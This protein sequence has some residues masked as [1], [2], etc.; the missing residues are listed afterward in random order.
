MMDDPD[1]VLSMNDSTLSFESSEAGGED[2]SNESEPREEGERQENGKAA[3][4]DGK[5]DFDK[6]AYQ[7]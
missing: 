4:V 3:D 1:E 7:R 5:E 6:E 2:N